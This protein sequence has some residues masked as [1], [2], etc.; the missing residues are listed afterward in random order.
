MAQP[1]G[2]PEFDG[3]GFTEPQVSAKQIEAFTQ[4]RQPKAG[5]GARLGRGVAG[6]PDPAVVEKR[7]R[8]QRNERPPQPD[9]EVHA[10]EAFRRQGLPG[11]APQVALAGQVAVAEGG[12]RGAGGRHVVHK[13][14]SG[15]GALHAKLVL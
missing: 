15:G 10:G 14:L 8:S 3:E 5:V 6:R 7:E 13:T 1:K 12:E 4:Q 2:E 9:F 11:V